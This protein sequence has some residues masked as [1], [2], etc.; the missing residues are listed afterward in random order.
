MCRTFSPILKPSRN[1]ENFLKQKS[2]E[3]ARKEL[4]MVNTKSKTNTESIRKDESTMKDTTVKT[5]I[6]NVR[7]DES[8]M[9]DT[10]VKTTTENVRKDEPTMKDPKAKTTIEKTGNAHCIDYTDLADMKDCYKEIVDLCIKNNKNCPQ[11]GIADPER[12]PD[13]YK[14]VRFASFT[15]NINGI[16]ASDKLNDTERI[17]AFKDAIFNVNCKDALDVPD[18]YGLYPEKNMTPYYVSMVAFSKSLKVK[19]PMLV[20]RNELPPMYAGKLNEKKISFATFDPKD[21][22]ERILSIFIA[23]QN[24]PRKPFKNL[25]QTISWI[26]FEMREVWQREHHYDMYWK[27]VNLSLT[28]AEFLMLPAMIDKYAYMFLVANSIFGTGTVCFDNTISPE[29]KEAIE[30]RMK[31]ISVDDIPELDTK[32]LWKTVKNSNSLRLF[33]RKEIE[34]A[35][36]K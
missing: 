9:K 7:K 13:E 18:I 17:N 16:F 22:L 8:T 31:S 1:E 23:E 20:I 19:C 14:T 5:T 3:N 36:L 30:K 12:I 35:I 15:G 29:Q 33:L 27:N 34:N 4:L 10:T 28:E 11:L 25:V 6:A 26:A 2:D 21:K 24:L 32:Q